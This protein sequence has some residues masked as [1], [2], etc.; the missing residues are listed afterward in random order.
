MLR[1]L[2]ERRTDMGKG[3][4]LGNSQLCVSFIVPRGSLQSYIRRN[5]PGR[6]SELDVRELL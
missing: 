2:D 5:A 6:I 4:W 1:C 3:K